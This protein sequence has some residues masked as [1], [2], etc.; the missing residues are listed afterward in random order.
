MLSGRTL[1]ERAVITMRLVA[2]RVTVGVAVDDVERA[3]AVC[4][5]DAVVV[6]GGATHRETMVAAFRA[7]SA[8]WVLVH[9][10]AHP[11]SRRDSRGPSS[12]LRARAAPP[13]PKPRRPITRRERA[14][15][16][17]SDQ[18]PSGWY[19]GRSDAGAPISRVSSNTVAGEEGLSVLLERVAVHTQLVPA[20]PGTSR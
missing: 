6:A 20:C 1:L 15:A 12:T 10:V 14:Y 4:G 5:S 16:N 19:A 8:P 9:D 13:S 17:G 18:A 3:Q 11:S 2:D 7:G